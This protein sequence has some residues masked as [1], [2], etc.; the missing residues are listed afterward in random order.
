MIQ[1]DSTEFNSQKLPFDVPQAGPL[2]KVLVPLCGKSV[3]MPG[4][5]QLH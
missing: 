2:R 1:H 5:L 4:S 3:D